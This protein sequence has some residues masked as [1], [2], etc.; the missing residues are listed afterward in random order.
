MKQIHCLL[1]EDNP[2]D[3]FLINEM[4]N[5][6]GA[7][8]Y[9]MTH[10]GCLRDAL[11]ILEQQSF[12][13]IISDLGLPDSEGLNTVR[14]VAAKVKYQPIIVMT[15]N[16]NEQ[17]GNDSLSLG[18]QDYLIKGTI[19]PDHLHR[20]VRYSFRRKK[21][22]AQLRESEEKFRTM[23]ETS[24]DGVMAFD[25]NGT[26]VYASKRATEILGY[27]DKE[28]LVGMSSERLFSV[29][30]RSRVKQ[31][32]STMVNADSFHD[33]EFLMVRKDKTSF[34]GEL[35]ASAITDDQG[36]LTGFLVVAKDISER[37]NQ[38]KAIQMY[39]QNL[40]SLTTQLNLAEEKERRN[41]AVEL[42]DHLGQRLALAK[43][44]LAAFK[45]LGLPSDSYENLEEAEKHI[46]HAIEYTRKLTYELSPPVLFELGLVEA[47]RWKIGQTGEAT[48]I[49]TDF[50]A[51]EIISGL[52]DDFL[53]L[54]FRSACE[55]LD[56]VAKHAKAG[57]V[58]VSMAMKKDVIT[59]KVEDDGIGFDPLSLLNSEDGKKMGLFSLRERLE[60]FDGS[61]IIN[62]SRGMGTKVEIAVP[63]RIK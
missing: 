5:P 38:E 42:H 58:K 23:V 34:F 18:A 27:P 16:D 37:K 61:L 33:E 55:L 14:E 47:L 31:R 50:S 2:A 17:V 57:T 53:I 1:I 10:A 35:S 62:S 46:N 3:V 28:N 15:S 6:G 56:N 24:P 40:R 26:I 7:G 59:V 20:S 48:G 13:I 45:H 30:D 52:K 11:N 44:R 12:D 49:K 36:L 4:L 8:K 39:Q 22:E 9:I 19:S 54:I 63:I 51:P 32:L 25:R 41:I 60:Y 43:I 29:G 21:V